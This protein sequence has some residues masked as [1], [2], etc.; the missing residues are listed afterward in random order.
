MRRLVDLKKA[1][2]LINHGP[3]VL[4]SSLCQGRTDITPI[5]WHMPVQKDP[6][7]IALVID[8]DS[9]IYE[10]ILETG[11][12]AVNIPSSIMLED[13]VT[14]G[15]VSGRDADKIKLCNFDMSPGK[16]IKSPNL[17]E[18]LAVMECVL[19]KDDHLL[20]EYNM[21]IGEVKYAEAEET[22]FH[23]HWS[24]ANDQMKT[25]HHLGDRTFCL[26]DSRIID[27]RKR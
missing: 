25:V 15:S 14:C 16:M 9:F 21:V 8:E 5:A 3:V 24:P 7:V 27:L 26:P 22:A 1:T 6:P 2:R 12:F 10:C 4:L 19:I 13:I 17:E 23:E 18:A 11:D 20:D